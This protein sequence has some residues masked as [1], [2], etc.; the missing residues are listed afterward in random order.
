MKAEPGMSGHDERTEPLGPARPRANI[1]AASPDGGRIAE[2][3]LMFARVLRAAGL[4]A[5]PDRTVLATQ[6]V[7]AAGVADQKVLY[8]TL[9]AVFV[10]RRADHDIFHQAFH[11]FWRD[12]GY[13]QQLL[14]VLVPNLRP[15]QARQ[16]AMARRLA[17]SLFTAREG[18]NAV[19]RDQLQVDASGTMSDAEGV[20][21]R[22]FEQ[23][24]AEELRLAR[25]VVREMGLLLKARRTRRYQGSRRGR[26]DLRG[27][28]RRAGARGP[29][30]L[31]PQYRAPR[32][33]TPPLVVL[34]DISGSMDVYARI[35][36]HFL[37]ALTNEG[38]RVHAFL[39]GTRLTNVT[40]LLREQDPDRAISR[41]GATV[42][43]WA[44][45]TRIGDSLTAFNRLWARRVLAQNA[46]VLLCTDGLDRAGGERVAEAARRMRASCRRLIWLNPLLRYD[47][48]QP[49]ASGA[50]ELALFASQTLPCHN[51]TSI[52][53]LGAVLSGRSN[54]RDGG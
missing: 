1:V 45:G 36:L 26:L 5:G 43:D 34:C 33:R 41:V 46:T 4:P 25:R 19:P 39:F 11:L 32:M 53:A 18:A 37:Y 28:L 12:P 52:A 51:L 8:W 40:R 24:T 47:G 49:L 7:L 42:T 10:Q 20:Q 16:D 38:D 29:D 48:Y 13:L 30:A 35:F 50:R 17:D 14:S 22:D 23:M 2:N 21:T 15:P 3:I 9:H 54:G 44:G 6:A 27:M 31:L